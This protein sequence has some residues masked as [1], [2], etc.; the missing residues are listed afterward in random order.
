MTKRPL[1]ILMTFLTLT[2]V[3]AGDARPSRKAQTR[4]EA[5]PAAPARRG[6][7]AMDVAGVRLDMSLADAQ[8]ALA[9]TY[10]CRPE[11]GYQ[12]FQQ[13]VDVEVA[14]RRGAGLGFPPQGTG[15]G[16]LFC[17]GPSGEG[18][19]V[20][21]AQTAAGPVVDQFNLTI[22]TNR[23]DPAGLVRQ[24]ETKYGTPTDGTAA[25][26][27]WCAGPCSPLE[28]RPAIRTTLS[29]RSLQ[30]LGNRGRL[31]RDADAAAVKAAADRLA[32]PAK[33]GAF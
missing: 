33:R 12:T 7:L 5:A 1:K 30:I 21:M 19:R 16:D 27:A 10:R 28:T 9:G 32:P 2:C 22:P 25:N 15:V 24:L 29:A 4:R 23:V 20:S 3:T 13:L 18:L 11:K 8:A 31:A 14:K 17:D 6:P 26:G